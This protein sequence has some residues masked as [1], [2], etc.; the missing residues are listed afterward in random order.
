MTYTDDNG[1]SFVESVAHYMESLI[2][3]RDFAGAIEQYESHRTKIEP[4]GAAAARVLRLA[5]KA[6]AGRTEYTPALKTARLAQTAAEADTDRLLLAEVFMTI[7]AIL[8][9]MGEFKEAERAFR[10]AESIFRRNDCPEGQSRALNQLA[11]L[12]FRQNDYRNSLTVL[13]DAVEIA[14]RLND[15]KKLAFMMGNIGRICTFTGDFTDAIKHLQINIELSRELHDQ[16][17]C[18]RAELSL[19]YVYI[20]QSQFDSAE[21]ALNRAYPMIVNENSRRDEICYLT[22]LGELYYRSGRLDEA[23]EVLNRAVTIARA[24]GAESPS[25][26]RALRHLAELALRRQDVRQAERHAAAALVI[27]DKAGDTVEVGALWKIRAQVA[28][29]RG[30]KRQATDAFRKSIELLDS[31]GVRWEKVE[32]MV[33]AG[34]S[35]SF[36]SRQRMTWLFRAEEFYAHTRNTK[37]LDRVARAI[38]RLDSRPADSGGHADSVTTTATAEYHTNC[39]E[40]NRFK[41]QLAMLSRSDLPVLLSGETGVG[42]D[43]MARYYHSLVRPDGPFVAINCAS[44]PEGLLE[45]ELFGYRKGAFTGA[46]GNKDGLFLRANGGVLF[47]DEIGDMPLT[48][49]AKLL[50]VL[51]RRTLIPLGGTTEVELDIKLVAATN[52]D[53]EAMVDDGTFR[54]DLYYRLSGI[55]FTI[56]PLRERREDIG[57]LVESFMRKRGL[58]GDSESVPAELLRSFLA[59]DWPG[60]VRELDNKVRRLEV[61]AELVNDGDLSELTHAVFGG[62]TATMSHENATLFER[63]EQF[64]R[65]LLLEA[66]SAARGNKSEAARLLGI[67]EAT[68]RTKLKRYNISYGASLPN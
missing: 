16:L 44:V 37:M 6:Y 4:T 56:P 28:D 58:L 65:E 2:G 25:L 22:Y 1:N 33:A 21:A 13:M 29:T 49:Q 17:E 60:N 54:R 66:L 30:Q 42:K 68:V 14:R 55:S 46:D 10:D 20:Q 18:A 8:R 41:A 64:E 53:L 15:K 23:G 31:S 34:L 38:N 51:E 63:V 9:D 67:H 45:S 26:G 57:M 12:F 3:T 61:M 27:M 35:E 19:A 36:D 50:G 32:A 62:E 48:L 5:A 39:E 11:G 24:D 43:H 40:I 47:L 7:G 59:Y 52:Q